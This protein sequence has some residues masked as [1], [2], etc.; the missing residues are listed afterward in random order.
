MRYSKTDAE[1]IIQEFKK[2]SISDLDAIF[3]RKTLPIFHEIEGET[4]GA[5]LALNPEN[6][7]WLRYMIRM[8]FKSPLGQWSGKN[9]ITPFGKEK[10]GFGINLFKNKIPPYLFKFDTYIKNAYIDEE[11]CLTLD[12]RPYWLSFFGL[13]DDV[14][15]ISDGLLL[16]QAY[17]KLPW[18]KQ[19]WFAG[20]FILCTLHNEKSSTETRGSGKK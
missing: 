14:R 10:K 18:R 4:A 16:G 1:Q 7:L 17:Y 6:P 20:Y 2:C 13:V 3:N 5:I 9:F 12:Y 19:M 8:I 11:P 15:K